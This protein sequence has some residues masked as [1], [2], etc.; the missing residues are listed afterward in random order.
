VGDWNGTVPTILAG[1]VPTGDQWKLVLDELTTLAGAWTSYTPGWSASAGTPSIGDG[2]LVGRYN[3][4]GKTL[5]L[6]IVLTAGPATTYGTAGAYWLFGLPTGMS[7]NSIS[8]GAALGLDAGVLEYPL[9][10]RA[11]ASNIELLKPGSGRFTNTSP[12]TFGNA[13]ILYISLTAEIT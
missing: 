9:F 5:S 11:T 3:R 6:N 2:T 12:W 13:D 8:I 4:I 1:D 7:A 10:A